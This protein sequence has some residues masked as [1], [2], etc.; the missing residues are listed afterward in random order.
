M[1]IVNSQDHFASTKNEG[2]RVL[3]SCLSLDNMWEM[4]I[5][6]VYGLY[7]WDDDATLAQKPMKLIVEII[8]LQWP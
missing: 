7:V 5:Y 8:I 3:E 6:D 4:K 2:Q 1:E